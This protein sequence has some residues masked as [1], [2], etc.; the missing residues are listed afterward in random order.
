M[1]LKVCTIDTY[2]TELSRHFSLIQCVSRNIGTGAMN[3][4]LP[5]PLDLQDLARRHRRG[6]LW[7]TTWSHGAA[8]VIGFLLCWGKSFVGV[9]LPVGAAKSCMRTCL[10]QAGKS[11]VPVI[12]ALCPRLQGSEYGVRV[13]DRPGDGSNVQVQVQV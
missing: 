3:A 2:L 5:C 13:L 12:T 9:W 4:H 10:V 6:M 7:I 11:V 8:K 1:N